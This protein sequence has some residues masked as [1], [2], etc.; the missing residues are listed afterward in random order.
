MYH[1]SQCNPN[2]K[3]TKLF[4]VD[5]YWIYECSKCTH[6]F[7]DVSLS[8][9]HAEVCYGDDYFEGGKAGYPDYLADGEML[10]KRGHYYGGKMNQFMS[11]GKMLDVGAAAGF[12]L[13]G[14]TDKGWTGMGIEPN[15]KMSNYAQQEFGLNVVNTTVEAFTSELKFDL[16]SMIQVLPHFYDLN[17]ALRKLAS[18]TK[19]GGYWLI[20]TWNKDSLTARI[21]Q[22]GWHEYSPPSVLHWFSPKTIKFFVEVYGMAFVA[23]GRPVK[24]ISGAHAKSLLAYK[25]AD[26]VLEK[27]YRI[28]SKL[29][30]DKWSFPYPAEDLFWI[31]LKK[32]KE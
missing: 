20:E 4:Q 10:R 9:I 32:V 5:N 30:P 11:P 19:K 15:L 31:L 8:S 6:R 12:I 29:I 28:A 27:P 21:L 26:S 7:A 2:R 17:Q 1:C 13:K 3:S 16:I 24:K 14:F 23:Q 25:F 22:K 18:L